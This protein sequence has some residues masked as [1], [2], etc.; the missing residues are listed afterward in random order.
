MKKTSPMVM[1]AVYAW[2]GHTCGASMATG[3]MAVQYGTRH[4]IPLGI[5][6]CLTYWVS[7]AVFMWICME[8]SRLI[9]AKNYRDVVETVYWP[10]K[11]VGTIMNFVWDL[12]SFFSIVV[13]S[14]TCVAGSGALFEEQFGFNYNLGMVLFV[15]IMLLLFVWGEGIMS[16]FGKMFVPMFTLLMIVCVAAVYMNRDNLPLVLSGAYKDAIPEGAGTIGAAMKDGFTL[17]CSSLGFACTAIVFAGNFE[18]RRDSTKTAV[19]GFLF[20]FFSL[21]L[22]VIATGAAFPDV[23]NQTLPFLSVLKT[24]DGVPGIILQTIY[25]VVLYVAYLSTV[26]SLLVGGTSRYTPVLKKFI[27]NEKLCIGIIVVVFLSISFLIGTTGLKAAV[28]KGFSF[29]GSLRQPLWFF[30]LLILGPISIH[31]KSSQNIKQQKTKESSI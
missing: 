27:S 26:S 1:G 10:N 25:V 29:L 7:A 11:A 18:S 22:C 4:G 3:L 5:L 14:G 16:R 2:F 30:P 15:A 28:T 12:I 24:I 31:R 13:V 21:S 20:G 17:G 6:S 8:Y 23:L 19:I 9:K